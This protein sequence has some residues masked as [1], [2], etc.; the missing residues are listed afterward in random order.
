MAK[1]NGVLLFDV[2]TMLIDKRKNNEL[3]QIKAK[4]IQLQ[5]SWL[6]YISLLCYLSI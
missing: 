1:V 6:S 2:I 5:Q 4:D 3:K